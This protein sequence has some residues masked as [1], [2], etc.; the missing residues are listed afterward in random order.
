MQMDTFKLTVIQRYFDQWDFFMK[1]SERPNPL[2][3]KSLS[4]NNLTIHK[5]TEN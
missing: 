5:K 1:Y 3:F 2:T 4:N